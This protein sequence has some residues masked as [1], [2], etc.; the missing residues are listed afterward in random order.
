MEEALDQAATVT[1]PDPGR[2][3]ALAHAGL[4]RMSGAGAV[5]SVE[6][7]SADTAV[8]VLT[9]EHDIGTAFDERAVSML[10]AAADL[11]AP[12]FEIKLRAHRLLAG[13]LADRAQDGIAALFGP[14]RPAVKLLTG[15]ALAALAILF[16]WHGSFVVSGRA[17]VEAAQLDAVVAPF[18]GFVA[19]AS[20][21][22]GDA[23]AAGEVLASLDDRELRLQAVQTRSALQE[24]LLK[25]GDAL[26]RQ[27]RVAIR[28][29]QAG[30]DEA[31]A[32]LAI[33]DDR[34]LRARLI[35]AVRGTVVS[36][37]LS[38]RIGAPVERGKTLFEVAPLDAWRVAVQVDERDIAAVRTGQPGRLLL[39]GLTGRAIRFSVRGVVPIATGADGRNTFRVE[40]ELHDPDRLLRPGM[41]G[42]GKICIDRRPVLEI[43]LRPVLAWLRMTI[44]TWWP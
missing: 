10:A 6:L 29:L 26:G 3:I 42:V 31:R 8:A 16:C 37:D 35:S 36:G 32:Q 24:Q 2:V 20:A 9:A 38:Q 19:A 39:A 23:V 40:A 7:R 11:L 18:D 30:I 14:R 44:W 13:R 34:L 5:C 25:Y 4:A 22:A 15:L 41:E 33:D 12:T 43:W 17:V 21:R 28:V 27:D 1:L